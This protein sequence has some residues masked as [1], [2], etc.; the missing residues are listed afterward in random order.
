MG[1]NKILKIMT[2]SNINGYWLD[3]LLEKH[4]NL[5]CDFG[6]TWKHPAKKLVLVSVF[7]ISI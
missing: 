2:Y 7:W 4:R 6:K 3:I 5:P 1:V